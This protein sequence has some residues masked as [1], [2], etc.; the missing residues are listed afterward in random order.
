LTQKSL[1]H[2]PQS[3][4]HTYAIAGIRKELYIW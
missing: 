2:C 1:Y 4:N 3:T